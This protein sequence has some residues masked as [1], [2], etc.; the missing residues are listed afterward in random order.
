MKVKIKKNCGVIRKLEG[1]IG[2]IVGDKKLSC[3]TIVKRIKLN[4][5]VFNGVSEIEHIGL[6]KHQFE[7]ID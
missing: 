5:P 3:G 6:G 2:E 1:K 7:R 4:K